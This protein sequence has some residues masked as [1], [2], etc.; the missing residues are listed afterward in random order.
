MPTPGWVLSAHLHTREQDKKNLL[1]LEKESNFRVF[2]RLFS[3]F[4][5]DQFSSAL[6]KQSFSLQPL[7]HWAGEKRRITMGKFSSNH[8]LNLSKR[9]DLRSNLLKI[10]PTLHAQCN[11]KRNLS[12]AKKRTFRIFPREN[13]L[14]YFES[15]KIHSSHSLS[16]T[17]FQGWGK[18]RGPSIKMPAQKN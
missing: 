2:R 16:F 7:P 14:H 18:Q 5:S 15:R 9:Q 12:C 11:E 6:I 10:A 3:C 1:L 8:S 13:F 4:S 17:W